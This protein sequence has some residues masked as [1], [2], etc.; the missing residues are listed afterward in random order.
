MEEQR[1]EVTLK[2]LLAVV[3]WRMRANQPSLNARFDW[4]IRAGN[5]TRIREIDSILQ[6]W[7]V[8]GSSGPRYAISRYMFYLENL[9]E[10]RPGETDVSLVFVLVRM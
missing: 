10:Q 7:T 3:P 4:S 5:L 2:S 6:K 1:E 8:F 9:R